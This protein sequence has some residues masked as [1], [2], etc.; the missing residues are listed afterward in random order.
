MYY[1][2][3]IQTDKEGKDS[4]G[5]YSYETRDEALKVFHQKMASGITAGLS[6]TLSKVLNMIINEHGG[7]EVKEFWQAPVQPEPEPEPEV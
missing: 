2:I 5:I 3:E 6:G 1:E 4:K 7:T